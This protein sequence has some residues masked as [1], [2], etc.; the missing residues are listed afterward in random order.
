MT[1]R[2]RFT[3]SMVLQVLREWAAV[4]PVVDTAMPSMISVIFLR[5]PDSA[6]FSRI[7]FQADFP[8]DSVP[9]RQGDVPPMRVPVFAM[10]LRSVSKRRSTDARRR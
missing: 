1:R 9:A 3:T 5:E 6:I 8:A 7:F 2:D 4:E 10:I